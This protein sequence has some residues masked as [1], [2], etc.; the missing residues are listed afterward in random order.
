MA[1]HSS[2]WPWK[3]LRTWPPV[4]YPERQDTCKLTFSG[5][6]VHYEVTPNFS[7]LYMS[8]CSCT[9]V[10]KHWSAITLKP[11]TC[12]ENTTDQLITVQCSAGKPWVLSFLRV[13]KTLFQT[14]RYAPPLQERLSGHNIQ[15]VLLQ[16]S[17][18]PSPS[19]IKRP[20]STTHSTRCKHPDTRLSR[21]HLHA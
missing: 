8:A 7:H 4:R 11:L 16:N 1:R 17:L 10:C 14:K 9:C 13:M 3:S 15:L 19:S 5:G 2:M 12:E 18:D 20:Y 6:Y 21:T